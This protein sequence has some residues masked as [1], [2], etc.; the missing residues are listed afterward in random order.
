MKLSPSLVT[1]AVKHPATRN[2]CLAHAWPVE[3]GDPV[4][5]HFCA[6]VSHAYASADVV[7]YRQDIRRSYT[8]G[9]N[10]G[11]EG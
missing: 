10:A 9:R 2:V 6:S 5:G 7:V 1:V 3:W 4:S 8:A 11:N